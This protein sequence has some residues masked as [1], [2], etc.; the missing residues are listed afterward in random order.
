VI[1][2]RPGKA[3]CYRCLWFDPPKRQKNQMRYLKEVDRRQVILIHFFRAPGYR[4]LALL[5]FQVLQAL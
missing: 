2:Q 4:K 5:K 1:Q 3:S